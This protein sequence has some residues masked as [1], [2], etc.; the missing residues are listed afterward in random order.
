VFYTEVAKVDR[1][2]AYVAMVCTC[3]LYVSVPN[4]YLFFTRMMQV[5]LSGC[6]ICFI[7][8]C[9]F[10]IWMLRMFCNGFQAF[11]GVFC[12]CFKRMFQVFHLSYV[13]CF[14]CCI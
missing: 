4:V 1:G 11:S 2:V 13:V 12:K 14:K 8:M 6:C 5:C 3:M 10:F 9:K 7:Y